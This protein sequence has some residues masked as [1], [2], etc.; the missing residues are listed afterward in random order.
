MDRDAAKTGSQRI[1]SAP[2]RTH[3][4]R[5]RIVEEI[6]RFVVLF[7]YLWLLFGLFGY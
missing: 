3:G 5:E 1:A 7:L 6:R 2:N 4:L